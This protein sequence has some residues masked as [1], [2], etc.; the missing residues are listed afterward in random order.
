MAI[1]DILIEAFGEARF[2]AAKLHVQQRLRER[3]GEDNTR[4]AEV[5]RPWGLPQFQVQFEQGLS[6]MIAASVA[7]LANAPTPPDCVLGSL[8][9]LVPYAFEAELQVLEAEAVQAAAEAAAEERAREV[10]AAAEARA[11]A[12]ADAAAAREIADAEAAV[13]V[14]AAAKSEAEAGALLL[15]QLH[16]RPPPCALF[17][18]TRRRLCAIARR[19]CFLGLFLIWLVP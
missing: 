3:D 9:T 4:S 19:G 11:V 1:K 13:L 8:D 15:Q 12:D 6:D 18:V 17:G 10:A 7:Q 14:A 5:A 16:I 2:N